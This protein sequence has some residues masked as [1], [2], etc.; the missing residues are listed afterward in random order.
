MYAQEVMDVF[1]PEKNFSEMPKHNNAA[2]HRLTIRNLTRSTVEL[3]RQYYAMVRACLAVP[4][5]RFAF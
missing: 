2:G 1:L 5:S 4:A 3:I